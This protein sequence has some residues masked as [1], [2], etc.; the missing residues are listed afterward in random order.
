[1]RVMGAKAIK[2]VKNTV[3]RKVNFENANLRRTVEAANRQRDAIAYIQ[4]KHG[5]DA[6]PP[7]LREIAA[8]RFENE[9]M[10]NAEL[11]RMLSESITPSGVSHRLARILRIAEQLK[12]KDRS[13]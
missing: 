1:M 12:E 4:Q 13:Q 11:A 3:N 6:L 2:S 9:G 10:S 5:F 8:L 7:E